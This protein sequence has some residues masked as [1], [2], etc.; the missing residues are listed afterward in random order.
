MQTMRC[1]AIRKPYIMGGES[2]AR[3]AMETSVRNGPRD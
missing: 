2:S 1:R 3:R